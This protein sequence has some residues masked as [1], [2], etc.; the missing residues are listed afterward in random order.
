MEHPE[1]TIV[2]RRVVDL[3]HPIR[4][5]IPIWPGDPPVQFETAAGIGSHGYFLRR[6]SMGE[7]NGTHL[8]TPSALVDDGAGP[9]SIAPEALVVPAVV[10][11]ARG[12][13]A[14]D[15]DYSLDPKDVIEWESRHGPVPGG[16]CVLLLTGWHRYWDEPKRFINLGTDG[17]M[18]TPGFGVE[19][20]RFLLDERSV[21][22]IGTDTHGVDTGKDVGLEVS[23]I[24]LQEGAMILECL[25]NLDQLPATGTTLIVGRLPLVGGSGCPASVLALTP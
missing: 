19:T 15:A 23:R 16:S 9:D 21:S 2:Y 22:G 25:N 8:S 12:P 10:I 13:G 1:L 14:S 3:T 7:H 4:P 5:G 20:V 17:L 11:D 6:F 18:H 24:A